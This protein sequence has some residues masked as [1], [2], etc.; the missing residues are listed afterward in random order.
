[1]TAVDPETVLRALA[2]EIPDIGDTFD[3]TFLGSTHSYRVTAWLCRC[4]S[5][6][7]GQSA[8]TGPDNVPLQFCR[9]WEAEYVSGAGVGATCESPAGCAGRQT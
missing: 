6:R 5:P 8:R 4:L 3:H 9:R 2:G 1:M 7:P